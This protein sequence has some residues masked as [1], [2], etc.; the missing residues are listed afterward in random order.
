M[1][2]KLDLAK[3]NYVVTWYVPSEAFE[4]QL[5]KL[6]TSRIEIL[7]PNGEC[8]LRKLQETSYVKNLLLKF[9]CKSI[10]VENLLSKC[11]RQKLGNLVRAKKFFYAFFY[12]QHRPML[13]NNFLVKF[14]FNGPTLF[15]LFMLFSKKQ[16]LQ[17]ITV[18]TCHVQPGFKSTTSRTCVVSHNH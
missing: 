6:E 15:R 5:V 10:W 13:K 16:F 17:Q 18:K 2:I 12:V 7:N 11:L 9:H 1:L 8:S 14:F 4:S 3:R